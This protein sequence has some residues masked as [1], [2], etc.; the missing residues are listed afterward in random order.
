MHIRCKFDG[1]KQI[2]RSQSGSWESRCAGA[3]LRQK[4]GPEWGPNTWKLITGTEPNIIFKQTASQNNKQVQRDR[5]SKST[6]EAKENTDDDSDKARKDYARYDGGSGVMEIQTDIPQEYLQG[7]ITQYYE[8]HV[9]VCESE[10]KEIEVLTRDQSEGCDI[11]RNKWKAERRKRSTSSM[12]GQIARRRSTT[13]VAKLVKTLLYSS[14]KGNAATSWGIT[15]ESCSEKQ[16]L[17][18]MRAE[19]PSITV[20]PSGL[21]ISIHHPWIAASPDGLVNDPSSSD[22]FGLVE[23]KNLYSHRNSDLQTAAK[24]KDFC[25]TVSQR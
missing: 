25:L 7:R 10:I 21:V 23:Y 13:K 6:E 4:L 5:K 16:Y 9:K 15:Q 24:S 18:K 8:A 2:N 3:G 1:G 19:S 12:M 22:T 20:S 11:Y 17:S 14:F